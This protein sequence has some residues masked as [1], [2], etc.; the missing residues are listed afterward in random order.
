MI[1][2]NGDSPVAR[3]IDGNTVTFTMPA[4]NVTI[5][6]TF[7]QNVNAVNINPTENGNV[8]ANPVNALEGAE[9]VLTVSPATGYKLIS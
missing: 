4:G 5:S 7:A 9:D 8:S 2:E 1:I 6:A 3:I